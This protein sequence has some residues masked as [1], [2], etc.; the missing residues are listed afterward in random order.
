MSLIKLQCWKCDIPGCDHVWIARGEKPKQC[1]KCRSRNWD[2]VL[3]IPAENREA[4]E[5]TLKAMIAH[6]PITNKELAKKVRES[7]KSKKNSNQNL[8]VLIPDTPA[9]KFKRPGHAEGCRCGMCNPPKD[10]K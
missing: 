2:T 7:K 1:A 3:V 8:E 4:F 9:P 6:P 5:N 10:G